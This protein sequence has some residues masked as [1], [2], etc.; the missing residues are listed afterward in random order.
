L[1]NSETFTILIISVLFSAA[2]PF[3]MIQPTTGYVTTTVPDGAIT[4]YSRGNCSIDI[5]SLNFKLGN[6]YLVPKMFIQASHYV[7]SSTLGNNDYDTL[8]VSIQ[9]NSAGVIAP[10]GIFTTTDETIPRLQTAFAGTPVYRPGP[11][12]LDN[13]HLLGSD[14]LQVSRNGNSISVNFNPDQPITLYMSSNTYPNPSTTI[15]LAM[16][17]FHIDFDKYGGDASNE[18]SQY[19]L[20]PYSGYVVHYDF[21]GFYANAAFTCTGWGMNNVAGSDAFITMHGVQTWIPPSQT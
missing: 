13:F 19:T 6:G 21:R 16:P 8:M 15:P 18:F 11:P 4:Y 1:K 2:L 20:V 5:T 12:A 17:S 9:V 10:L 7:A 3:A 14:E